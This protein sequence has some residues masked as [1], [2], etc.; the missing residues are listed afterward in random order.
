MQ[1]NKLNL[2]PIYSLPSYLGRNGIYDQGDTCAN[3]FSILYVEPYVEPSALLVLLTT[4]DNWPVRSPD[5]NKWY[6]RPGRCSRDQLTPYLC[7]VASQKSTDKYFYSVLKAMSKHAFCFANNYVRNF[8]YEDEQEHLRKSTSDVKWRPNWKLPDFLGPDIWQIWARGLILRNGIWNILR[9]ILWLGDLQNFCAVLPYVFKPRVGVTDERNLGL[10]VHFAAHFVP[11]WLSKL[12]Y[13]LY[14][15]T[16]P[17][18]AFTRFWTQPGEP[19]VH[20]FMNR[21]YE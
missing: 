18:V 14:K 15:S 13:K 2:D 9:P 8:V 6:G 11:T 21:L 3:T 7:Y 5:D 1:E 19:A 10:K 16:K 12:T 20:I 4:E 17:Q